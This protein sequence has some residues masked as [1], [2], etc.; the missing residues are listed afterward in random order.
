MSGCTSCP[1][2]GGCSSQAQGGCSTAVPQFLPLAEGNRI[3]TVVAVG[4]GKGGVGKSTVTALL[5]VMLRREGYRVGI[6]DADVTGPSMPQAFGIEEAPGVDEHQHLI[7]PKTQLDLPI[8]SLNLLLEDKEEPVVWRGPVIGGVIKQFWQEVQWGHLDVL[9]I[10]MPPGTGDVPLTV[11][12]SLPVDRFLVVTSPQELVRVIVTKACRMAEKM[13]VPVLGLV[14]N[15]SWLSCGDC[16]HRIY[17]FGEGR[18]QAVADQ[19]GLPLLDQLPIDPRINAYMDEGQI[20]RFPE[21]RLAGSVQA[22]SALIQKKKAFF[23]SEDGSGDE[24]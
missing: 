19:L 11:F 24:G 1:S 7:P 22:I 4:S 21:A 6:L 10:D 20:E 9:L 2:A 15:L 5:A 13:N 14:E 3:L 12:Q 23:E 18:S 8:M 16:H 17:P